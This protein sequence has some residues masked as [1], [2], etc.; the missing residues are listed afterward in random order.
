MKLG[1]LMVDLSSQKPVR[2]QSR[3]SIRVTV[4]SRSCFMRGLHDAVLVD[5]LPHRRAAGISLL[6]YRCGPCSFVATLAC[7][8]KT[9]F[10]EEL[11]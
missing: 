7:P 6:T 2:V 9:P 1:S 10:E 4:P 3:P 8:G 11:Y 5:I